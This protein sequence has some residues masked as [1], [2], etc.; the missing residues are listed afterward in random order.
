MLGILP[1]QI[2][3]IVV[4]RNHELDGI[5]GYA[6][7]AIIIYH[8]L[9]FFKPDAIPPFSVPFQQISD[10]NQFIS[11]ISIT[12]FNGRLA[13]TFFFILSGVVLFQSLC[14]RPQNDFFTTIIDFTFK[15]I[16]RIYPALIGFLIIFFLVAKFLHLSSPNLFWEFSY[17]NLINNMLLYNA[18]ISFSTWTLK[19]EILVIPFILLT[20]YS[21]KT[22]GPP[23]LFIFLGYSF[24][25]YENS[26]LSFNIDNPLF[27]SSLV[28]FAFGFFIPTQIGKEIFSFFKAEHSIILLL[29]ASLVV[30]FVFISATSVIIQTM[31]A[32]L[33]VGILYHHQ[34]GILH[35]IFTTKF[36]VYFGKISYSL[37]LYNVISLFIIC[38]LSRFY[39]FPFKHF[40]LSGLVTGVL[41]II[42]TIPLAHFSEKYIEQTFIKFNRNFLK[43]LFSRRA[44]NSYPL[45]MDKE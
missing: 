21:F 24:L 28:Y 22:F 16:A 11:K 23:A 10:F 1:G 6:C 38:Q 45:V 27:N 15:R 39:I 4:G 2:G 19:V 14:N 5:R 18:N 26:W 20:F 13:L 40:I 9:L 33:V 35:K 7:L 41:A 12:L 42:I 44:I 36:A 17:K 43:F 37:Y 25:V 29:L 30:Q 31:F 32:F 34:S 3:E 8:S